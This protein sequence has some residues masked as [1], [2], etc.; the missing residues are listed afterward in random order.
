MPISTVY[1][2]LFDSIQ[3]H[4][5]WRYNKRNHVCPKSLH[6]DFFCQKCGFVCKS[7]EHLE[8]HMREE[9]PNRKGTKPDNSP[10]QAKDNGKLA[11][12]GVM[13]HGWKNNTSK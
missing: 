2:L 9:C 6:P 3:Q 12:N 8:T 13:T 5:T 7:I 1:K 10:S 4:K 11:P